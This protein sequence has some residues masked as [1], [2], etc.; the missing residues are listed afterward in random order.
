ML[1]WSLHSVLQSYLDYVFAAPK[2]FISKL[3]SSSENVLD[4]APFCHKEYIN[5]FKAYWLKIAW[6]IFLGGEN[7]GKGGAGNGYLKCVYI[8]VYW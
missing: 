7:D 6:T 1:K 8:I 4:R 3:T 2:A 5:V